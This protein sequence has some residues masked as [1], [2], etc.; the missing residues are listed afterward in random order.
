MSAVTVTDR[1]PRVSAMSSSRTPAWE[2]AGRGVAQA[3]GVQVSDSG[4]VVD[5][6][7]GS[8]DVGGA[9]RA[10]CFR[11]EYQP[12]GVGPGRA[13][14]VPVSGLVSHLGFERCGAGSGAPGSVRAA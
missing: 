8:A 5:G 14:G 7:Q 12:V 6:P 9:K 13:R 11:A 1:R 3:V 2:Q 10:S 4:G